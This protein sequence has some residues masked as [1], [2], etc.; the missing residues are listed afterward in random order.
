I[1]RLNK[2]L[3]TII[4]DKINILEIEDAICNNRLLYIEN[5]DEFIKGITNNLYVS[6]SLRNLGEKFKKS[7]V[8]YGAFFKYLFFIIIKLRKAGKFK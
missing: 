2:K 7:P 8:F 3:P 5:V 4:I 6:E 1:E